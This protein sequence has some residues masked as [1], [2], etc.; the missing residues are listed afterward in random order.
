MR[1]I[2]DVNSFTQ[3]IKKEDKMS[4]E[5]INQVLEEMGK[6]WDLMIRRQ[7]NLKE[8]KEAYKK[9][10]QHFK[11]DEPNVIACLDPLDTKKAYANKFPKQ[12]E[13]DQEDGFHYVRFSDFAG[14]CDHE[15]L[16]YHDMHHALGTDFKTEEVEY[17]FNLLKGI[18]YAGVLGSICT[19]DTVF[20]CPNPSTFHMPLPKYGLSRTD[21]PALAWDRGIEYYMIHNM[22]VTPEAARSFSGDYQRV[23][24]IYKG[25]HKIQAYGWSGPESISN[26]CKRK[27]YLESLIKPVFESALSTDT[28]YVK[29]NSWD[30]ICINSLIHKP[31][32]NYRKIDSLFALWPSLRFCFPREDDYRSCSPYPYYF[33]SPLLPEEI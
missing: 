7:F 4:R 16:A 25:K 11:I 21:G 10:Y 15:W 1:K 33:N 17:L 5:K 31:L 26:R 6:Q 20:C 24:D 27:D 30:Y 28:D 8:A 9:I 19:E 32:L 14:V 12:V 18:A 3:T 2:F 29:L 13:I 23:S 22:I